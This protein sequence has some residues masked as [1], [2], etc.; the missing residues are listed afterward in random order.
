[1]DVTNIYGE[2]GIF[3]ILI[4]NTSMF[5]PLVYDLLYKHLLLVHLGKWD[6]VRIV[7]TLTIT[8]LI[9]M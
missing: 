7:F 8:C 3:R 1:M 5:F 2:M 4:L 6:L 9:F